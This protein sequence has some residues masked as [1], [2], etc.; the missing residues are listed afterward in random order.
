MTIRTIRNPR[1]AADMKQ[2]IRVFNNLADLDG[3]RGMRLTWRGR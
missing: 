2:M 3:K 1:T